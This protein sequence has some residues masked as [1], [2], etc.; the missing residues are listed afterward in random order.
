MSNWVIKLAEHWK[1]RAD[2]VN[3][4]GLVLYTDSDPHI[5]KVIAD[6]D[7]WAALDEISGPKAYPSGS[8][9]PRH[10]RTYHEQRSCRGAPMSDF[11]RSLLEF[12]RRFPDDAA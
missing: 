7:Y 9:P 4:F 8:A 1:G 12:Q 6:D 10:G 3:A 5:K 2:I 11:P